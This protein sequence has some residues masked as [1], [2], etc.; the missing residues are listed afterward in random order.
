MLRPLV[1]LFV[2]GMLAAGCSPQRTAPAPQAA[3]ATVQ[4]PIPCDD[5]GDGG[6]MLHGVC[7]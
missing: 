7:L 3:L 1:M 4:Q 6:V 2:A 5:G